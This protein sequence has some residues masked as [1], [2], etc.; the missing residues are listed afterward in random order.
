MANLW[1][2]HSRAFFDDTIVTN[3]NAHSLFYPLWWKLPLTTTSFQQQFSSEKNAFSMQVFMSFNSLK[4]SPL[5]SDS[6]PTIRVG[7]RC[8]EVPLY[9]YVRTMHKTESV[10]R[11][12]VKLRYQLHQN[13]RMVR[14]SPDQL[15]SAR[16]PP[17]NLHLP[18]AINS[19]SGLTRSKI[20]NFLGKNKSNDAAAALSRLPSISDVSHVT[21]S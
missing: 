5:L 2:I 4:G 13:Q 15:Q 12:S 16:F 14:K 7:E 11:R 6:S 10:G 17:Q 9:M 21:L 19:A 8:R 18:G 20:S 1:T 3:E